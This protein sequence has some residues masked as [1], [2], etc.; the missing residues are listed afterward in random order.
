MQAPL[1]EAPFL[2][3]PHRRMNMELG[4]SRPAPRAKGHRP[5]DTAAA[6]P[7]DEPPV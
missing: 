7:E 6:L 5:E 2:Y 3:L 4:E 1:A